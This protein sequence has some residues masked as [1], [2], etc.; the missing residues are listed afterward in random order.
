[1]AVVLADA[2]HVPAAPGV[3]RAGLVL[4]GAAALAMGLALR[5]PALTAVL[6][7]T[8]FGI[9]HN[10]FELRYV[11]GRFGDVL[12]G[13]LLVLLLVFITVIAACRVWPDGGVRARRVEVLSAYALLAAAWWWVRATLA[14]A[15]AAA[16]WVA[17]GAAAAAS[18]TLLDYHFVVLVHLH[19]IVPLCFLWEWSRRLPAGRNVFRAVNLA[20]VA[21]LPALVLVGAFDRVL[22]GTTA[23][24]GPLGTFTPASLSS[25]Y[26][27]PA[28]ATEAIG[29]RFLVVF[30]FMQTMHYVVWVWF[31]PRHAPAATAAFERRVPELRGGRLLAVCVL[32]AAAL[33]LLMLHDYRTGK[34]MY[35]AVASYH[36][37]LEFPVLLTLVFGVANVHASHG[38]ERHAALVHHPR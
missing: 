21:V 5:Q 26:T 30:A 28:W 33:A 6:G 22:R 27:P 29:A 17:L 35:G 7:L 4:A 12:T 11:A 2:V 13:R 9:V 8:V 20:W 36:A 24:L 1:M 19:N 23:R 37:Y 25:A 10:G 3:R 18:L 15:A 38:K 16:G 34:T 32:G 14:R 31:F